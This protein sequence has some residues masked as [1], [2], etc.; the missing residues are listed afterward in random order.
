VCIC[1]N[2]SLLGPGWDGWGCTDPSEAYSYGFQL[3][4]TLLLCLS[5]LMFVP[6]VVIA[7]RGHYL[8]EASVYIFTMFFST[9]YHACDQPGIVVF[10]IMEYD[11]LQFCDFLGSLMS[12]WVTVISM[13]RLKSIIKQVLYLLGAMTLSMALQLD[14]HGLWNLLGPSLFAL[15]IMA[16]A[17]QLDIETET[18][19]TETTETEM[20]ETTETEMTETTETEMTETTETEMTENT[21]TEMTE[22]TETEMTETTETTEDRM[23]RDTGEEMTERPLRQM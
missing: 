9:F 17:W 22:T 5:N 13:A 14:R 1:V 19:M 21:E 7:V 20:T 15:G 2:L 10:C 8:L 3:L 4:S 16:V 11:V 6:P 12:V 23:N 18:E